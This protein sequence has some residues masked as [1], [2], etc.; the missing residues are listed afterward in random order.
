[1]ASC[2]AVRSH[3]LLLRCVEPYGFLSRCVEPHG[4][5][6][7][8]LC[9]AWSTSAS[10]R[11]LMSS[12]YLP[13]LQ[14][15]YN[16]PRSLMH[17]TL[18]VS[19][20]EVGALINPPS[21]KNRPVPPLQRDKVVRIGKKR[22]L[23]VHSNKTASEA[24]EVE[25]AEEEAAGEEAEEGV[26]GAEAE[27]EDAEAAEEAEAEVEAEA[28]EE[29]E[30]DLSEGG[31]AGT[32]RVAGLSRIAIRRRHCR[33]SS[34]AGVAAGEGSPG[35]GDEAGVEVSYGFALFIWVPTRF[36]IR[37]SPF[38]S[39]KN[40]THLTLLPYQMKPVASQILSKSGSI[41][42]SLTASKLAKVT[43]P[44][45]FGTDLSSKDMAGKGTREEKRTLVI[46][47]VKSLEDRDDDDSDEEE[48]SPFNEKNERKVTEFIMGLL[49]ADSEKGIA[50]LIFAYC[51]DIVYLVAKDETRIPVR[52]KA[53]QMCG[54]VS[55]S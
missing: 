22:R 5:L 38:I 39:T 14:G 4:L 28:E 46:L 23:G 43:G 47:S 16:L 35:N 19:R 7:R 11:K 52:R 31:A 25:E 30:E 40:I 26:V 44:K 42:L 50:R 48:E 29:E 37:K 33:M 1:M 27:E 34:M 21:H 8:A 54:L 9:R 32:I 12:K 13:L 6:S 36:G 41:F 51:L 24:E 17:G 2:C 15:S 10:P 18:E 55:I 20:T 49:P 3:G 45:K 53:A